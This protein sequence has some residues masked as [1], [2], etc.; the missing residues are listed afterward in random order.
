[1]AIFNSD[2]IGKNYKFE[3]YPAA[4]IGTRFNNVTYLGTIDASGVTGFDPRAK[5]AV[6]FPYLPAGTGAYN[7]YAYHRFR[8]ESGEVS[9]VGDPWIKA[10]TVI[11][12]ENTKIVVTYTNLPPTEVNRIRQMNLNNDYDSFTIEVV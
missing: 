4:V 9:F 1:M 6:V 7:T 12:L 11:S 8:L 3:I 2:N 10:N 5:H